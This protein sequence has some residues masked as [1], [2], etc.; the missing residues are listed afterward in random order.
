[1]LWH[2]RHY[3]MT[4]SRGRKS[5]VMCDTIIV[6]LF[7]PPLPLFFPKVGRDSMVLWAVVVGS[8]GV[9]ER[10]QTTLEAAEYA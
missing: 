3:S 1:M 10:D 7:C 4:S 9:G 5:I 8:G 6:K 2:E